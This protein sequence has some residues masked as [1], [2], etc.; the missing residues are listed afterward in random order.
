M[1]IRCYLDLIHTVEE[2]VFAPALSLIILCMPSA[3]ISRTVSLFVDFSLAHLSFAYLHILY[4]F[5]LLFIF[6]TSVIYSFFSFRVF[7]SVG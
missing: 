4:S 3:S 7:F 2:H 6:M 5:E 1:N